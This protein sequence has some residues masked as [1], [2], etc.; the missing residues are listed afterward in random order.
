MIGAPQEVNGMAVP[1]CTR[2]SGR[3][4][5]ASAMLASMSIAHAETGRI[6]FSGAVVESTCSTE[7]AHV[8]IAISSGSVDGLMSRKLTC[9]HTATDPGRSYS[10][11]VVSL[12]AAIIANDR[13]L[14]Y[15]ASYANVTGDGNWAKVVTRT[16]D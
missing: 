10:R 8:G 5:I 13:L 15:F 3:V 1:L 11:D 4:L 16:Y 14:N 6:V 12:D 7:D 2:F 9:G